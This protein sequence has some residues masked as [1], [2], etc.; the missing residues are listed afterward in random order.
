MVKHRLSFSQKGATPLH[1]YAEYYL[2]NTSV[3]CSRWFVLTICQLRLRSPTRLCYM[4]RSL[5]SLHQREAICP[6]ARRKQYDVTSFTDGS[7]SIAIYDSV[8]NL[9][10]ILDSESMK[11]H[12][13]NVS[14]Q[15]FNVIKNISFTHKFLC[16]KSAK[17]LT[18]S[19]IL[20]RLDYFNSQLAGP[21]IS[22]IAGLDVTW[23]ETTACIIASN[24]K[25]FAL[26]TVMQA[27]LANTQ[28]LCN[29]FKPN[30]TLISPENN[31]CVKPKT[32]TIRYDQLYFSYFLIPLLIPCFSILKQRQSEENANPCNYRL[33]GRMQS[34][35]AQ[36]D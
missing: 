18:V 17:T 35:V 13:G 10:V 21:A 32:N 4:T 29:P 16:T 2:S 15:C 19:L 9:A 33:V 34:W 28:Q 3:D 12:V 5:H 31:L 14:K 26:H 27:S 7:S 1:N 30:R 24:S 25:F 36:E 6:T 20:S 11:N 23:P 22:L 8:K